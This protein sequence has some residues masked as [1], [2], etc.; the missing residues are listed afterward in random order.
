MAPSAFDPGEA[1][2]G[3][4]STSDPPPPMVELL[5]LSGLS[6][7]MGWKLAFVDLAMLND[8][9]SVVANGI[10]CA[11]RSSLPSWRG[12]NNQRKDGPLIIIIV[13]LISSAL[14]AVG[15]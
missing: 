15:L 6:T 1:D 13:F 5:T 4:A 9:S 11:A 8:T 12:I 2:T 3:L 14:L 7:S 10:D